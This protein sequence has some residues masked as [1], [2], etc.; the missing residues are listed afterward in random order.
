[1]RLLLIRREELEDF[2][3]FESV[4]KT[5]QKKLV[6]LEPNRF[7]SVFTYGEKLTLLT[8][9]IDTIHDLNDFRSFMNTRNEQKSAFNKDKMD[10][11]QQI[12]LLEAQYAEK[13]KEEESE[14]F[15]Q[16]I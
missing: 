12:K 7:S 1:M 5:I 14:E 15:V 9:L 8:V 16:K 13:K 6:N 11:Y 4:M 3:E 2:G 10:V